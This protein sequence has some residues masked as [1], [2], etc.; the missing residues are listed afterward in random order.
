[1]L[2][3][4]K[5]MPTT[6]RESIKNFLISISEKDLYLTLEKNIIK[7]DSVLDVGCGINSPL[8]KIKKVNFLEGFDFYLPK[9]NKKSHFDRFRKGNVVELAKFYKKGSF[10]VVVALDLIEHVRK[11][12]GLLLLR[13]MEKIARK[14]IIVFTPNGFLPQKPEKNNPF[15]EHLSGWTIGELQNLGYRCYG[16]RGIKWLRGEY[17]KV[18]RKP[19]L[20]WQLLSF[21]TEPFCYFFPK[22]AFQILAIKTKK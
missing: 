20:L 2:L 13:S 12:D 6:L 14:K 9:K 8:E 21:L 16:I 15:Q 4:D 7:E 17:G 11:N 22:I 3:L 19:F 18:L 1:M 10:D 5:F